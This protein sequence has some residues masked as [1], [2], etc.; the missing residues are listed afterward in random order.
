MSAIHVADTGLFVA[1]GQPS[2]PRH[3]AVRSFAAR[4]GITFVL[5]EHVYDEL[6]VDDAADSPPIDTAIEEGW[7]EIAEPIDYTDSLVSRAMDGV[8]RFIAN[9]DDRPEDEIERAD[10]AL[11]GVAAQALGAGST[12]HAYVYTTDVATGRRNPPID[13]L[14]TDHLRAILSCSGCQISLTDQ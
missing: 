5:P 6:T 8:R 3:R 2:N 14:L 12:S 11:A 10:T 1:I 7:A 9:A 13:R 4:N